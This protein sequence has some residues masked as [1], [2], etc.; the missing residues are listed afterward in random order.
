MKKILLLFSTLVSAAVISVSAKPVSPELPDWLQDKAHVWVTSYTSVIFPDRAPLYNY[1]YEDGDSIIDGKNCTLV[2]F[3]GWKGAFEDWNPYKKTLAYFIEDNKYYV[4]ANVDSQD[5]TFDLS[6]DFNLKPGDVLS[7]TQLEVL[8]VDSVPVNGS[9][10]KRIA[11][12]DADSN[13]PSA[14]MIGAW[15]NGIGASDDYIDYHLSDMPSN[16][17]TVNFCGYYENG[18]CVFTYEDFFQPYHQDYTQTVTTDKVWE[19]CQ[20]GGYHDKE[21]SKSYLKIKVQLLKFDGTVSYLDHDYLRFKMFKT[22]NY[23]RDDNQDWILL[24]EE[25]EDMTMGYCREEDGKVY[26]L[27]YDNKLA[28]DLSTCTDPTLFSEIKI[29]DWSMPE[30]SIWNYP[31]WI[32]ADDET[33]DYEVHYFN[34]IEIGGSE[35]KVQALD[36]FCNNTTYADCVRFIQGIG[37]D[38]NAMLAAPCFYFLTGEPHETSFPSFDSWLGRVYDASGDVIWESKDYELGV[39]SIKN[40]SDYENSRI[41]DLMG[42]EVKSMQPGGIYIRNGKKFIGR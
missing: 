21:N 9:N 5:C 18:E 42:R 27:L 22:K 4:N 2:R 37:V 36:G 14:K 35:C 17:E 3:D 12:K 29:Y 10:H 28:M 7:E 26:D 20:R 24:N 8:F 33:D 6:M 23:I 32:Y 40:D 11:F 16:G 1:Y 19:Y 25:D 39:S 30:N 41:Y 31:L 38:Q 34:P 15:V 13:S